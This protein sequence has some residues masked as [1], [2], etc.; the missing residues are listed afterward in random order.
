MS[1]NRF[2]SGRATNLITIDWFRYVYL[3]YFRFRYFLSYIC[4]P[5]LSLLILNPEG[6]K[7]PLYC[8]DKHIGQIIKIPQ[9]SASLITPSLE[10]KMRH[11]HT[12]FTHLFCSRNWGSSSYHPYLKDWNWQKKELEET[13]TQPTYTWE[14][15]REGCEGRK[16][17]LKSEGM[18]AR[19][20]QTSFT[21]HP[22]T[23]DLAVSS[24]NIIHILSSSL[25]SVANSKST[26]LHHHHLRT[27]L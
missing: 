20:D 8:N 12:Y 18:R 27:H 16:K 22:W 23:T 21:H 5:V 2:F 11:I 10:M 14:W 4:F 1:K 3:S 7:T 24:L 25:N 9:L 19:E 17:C 13:V 6:I 15:V 26:L